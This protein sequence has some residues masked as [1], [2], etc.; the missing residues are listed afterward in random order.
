MSN[1]LYHRT[2]SLSGVHRPT[3][4]APCWYISEADLNSHNWSWSVQQTPSEYFYITRHDNGIVEGHLGRLGESTVFFCER[5]YRLNYFID[6]Y[7]H[8][9]V[10]FTF[11]GIELFKVESI[12]PGTPI[13]FVLKKINPNTMANKEDK[14]SIYVTVHGQGNV[15]T[16]G[17]H[18]KVQVGNMNWKG[19]LGRLTA[20]FARQRVPAEDIEEIARIVQQEQPDESGTLPAKADSWIKKM[21]H[22]SVDGVWH[23]GVHA[24][25]ALLA[26]YIKAYYGLPF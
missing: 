10:H 9:K 18:N 4:A 17:D 24:A 25:G 16:T 7:A 3:N 5:S 14:N 22:K 15:V 8:K 6:Y 19:D 13:L 26:E 12:L 11:D 2:A 23:V 1:Q 20:E 21:L